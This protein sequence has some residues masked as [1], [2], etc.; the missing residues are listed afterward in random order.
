MDSRRRQTFFNATRAKKGICGFRCFWSLIPVSAGQ[1]ADSDRRETWLKPL[2][3][4]FHDWAD[5]PENGDALSLD[6]KLNDISLYW[7]T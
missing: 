6:A 4:K 2:A 5:N 1:R 7:F 3:E